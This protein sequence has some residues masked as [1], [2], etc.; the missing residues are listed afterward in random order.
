MKAPNKTAVS[1]WDGTAEEA[2]IEAPMRGGE[3]IG[4]ATEAATEVAIVGGGFTGLSAALHLSQKGIGAHVLEARS[5]G[6]GGSGRN[7]GL[8]NAGLWLPPQDIIA[9]LGEERGAALVRRLCDA[10]ACVFA[11]IDKHQIRCEAARCGTIHAAHS[12]RGY[13]EL[14]RRFDDWNRLGAAVELLSLEATAEQTGAAGFYGGLLDHRAGTI[15]PMGYARGLARAAIAAGAVVNTGVEVKTLQRAAGKWHLD[16]SAGHVTAD[17]VVLATNAYTGDLWRALR[18]CFTTIYYFQVATKPLGER[19]AR[20]LPGG[21]GLWTTGAI[22][23]SL[24]RDRFGRIIIGSMGR[25]IGGARGGG[26]SA[27]WARRSLRRL[28]PGL[29]EV[30]L[31]TAWHG[32]IAMTPDHLP[33]IYRLAEDLYAPIGYNGRGIAP[34]TAFGMAMADFLE[35]GDESRLP[36]PVT[37]LKTAPGAGLKSRLYDAAFTANQMFKNTVAGR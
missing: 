11:L 28:F 23:F 31:E 1:L 33:R 13:D 22:M 24:R 27:R 7:A 20:I 12:P 4:A 36:L 26:I 32:Q 3:N 25:V 2:P 17:K 18:R 19:A 30:E 15:N 29:G 5:I 10:P 14:R 21:H 6:H 37:A 8:V 9:R 34:G 16:T 35:S